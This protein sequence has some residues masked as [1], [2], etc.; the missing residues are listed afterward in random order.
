MKDIV[1]RLK[2]PAAHKIRIKER[3]KHILK[4]EGYLSYSQEL[5]DNIINQ[6]EGDARACLNT[7]QF[8]ATTGRLE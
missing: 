8:F 1:I 3:V 2:V 4:S 5:V 7:I 6:S